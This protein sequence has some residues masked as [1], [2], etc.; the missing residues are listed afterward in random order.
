MTKEEFET[1]LASPQRITEEGTEGLKK[2]LK[3]FPYFQSARMLYLR[4]LYDTKSIAFEEHLSLMAAYSADRKSLYYFLHPSTEYHDEYKQGP[5]QVVGT[6]SAEGFNELEK[7]EV[8]LAAPF[9]LDSMVKELDKD[10]LT[11]NYLH[12]MVG[13][14]L[15]FDLE[16]EGKINQKSKMESGQGKGGHVSEQLI[17]S[18]N[19]K[20]DFST[21]LHI[22]D[23]DKPPLHGPD[24]L[25]EQ[26]LERNP[27]MRNKKKEDATAINLAKRSAQDSDEIITETLAKIHLNQGNV[28]KALR[29]Y[30][31]LSL[32]YPEKSSYFAAQIKILKQK[33]Q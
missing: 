8:E 30:E 13:T 15:S 7:T 9:R 28:E 32:R 20:H 14:V 2:L 16:Q 1:F 27:Q 11:S 19:E 25:I 18:I 6:T 33:L 3:E 29:I 10:D 23:E 26:F 21:W 17:P 4:K 12:E 22:F 5:T 31:K 24:Q